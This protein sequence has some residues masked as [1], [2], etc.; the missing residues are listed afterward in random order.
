MLATRTRPDF[1]GIVRR[2]SRRSL[3]SLRRR[4]KFTPSTHLGRSLTFV[5]MDS[6]TAYLAMFDFLERY[7]QM[8]QSDD[9]GGLLGSMSLVEDEQ[10]TADPAIWSDW[11][12][13]LA[14]AKD[15]EVDATMRL[16]R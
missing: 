16:S 1:S 5:H 14:R 6:K 10:V 8:T 2:Q 13:S 7:Y 9:I 3:A 12:A 4:G 15:G 11:E